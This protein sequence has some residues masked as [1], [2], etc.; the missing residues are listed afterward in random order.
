MS[1]PN[2]GPN[3]GQYRRE[4]GRSILVEWPSDLPEPPRMA[5][6]TMAALAMAQQ[7]LRL[8]R[9]LARAEHVQIADFDEKKRPDL[10]VTP[11]LV[12]RER[13]T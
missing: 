1:N 12:R 5:L 9:W 10:K 8:V 4:A 7:W 2:A 13:G 3:A 11:G 6:A